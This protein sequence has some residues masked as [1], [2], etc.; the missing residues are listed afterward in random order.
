MKTHTHTHTTDEHKAK[1]KAANMCHLDRSTTDEVII[2]SPDQKRGK[3]PHRGQRDVRGVLGCK[4]M[5]LRQTSGVYYEV[6]LLAYFYYRSC[7]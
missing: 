3:M 5:A 2:K 1:F 7:L 4:C 6:R